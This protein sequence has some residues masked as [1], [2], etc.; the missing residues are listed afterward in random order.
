[1]R[2]ARNKQLTGSASWQTVRDATGLYATAS[3]KYAEQL[4]SPPR[5]WPTPLDKAAPPQAAFY[6][7]EATWAERVSSAT[8]ETAF[9][10]AWD[11]SPTAGGLP[12]GYTDAATVVTQACTG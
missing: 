1:M 3:R 6:R 2:A 4:L 9:N 10:T 11:Q 12:P 5:P 8:T 7:A